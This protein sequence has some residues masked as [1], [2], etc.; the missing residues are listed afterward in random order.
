M[1]DNGAHSY[2]EGMDY[3]PS[4]VTN[5]EHSHTSFLEKRGYKMINTPRFYK[6]GGVFIAFNK[7]FVKCTILR[8]HPLRP[9]TFQ[10]KSQFNVVYRGSNPWDDAAFAEALWKHLG[11]HIDFRKKKSFDHLNEEDILGD[12]E[13]LLKF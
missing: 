4:N 8:A 5:Q 10:R 9:D 1:K 13:L 3:Q 12:M 7:K 11:L 2:T 6:Q